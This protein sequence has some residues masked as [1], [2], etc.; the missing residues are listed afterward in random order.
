MVKLAGFAL[1]SL[2]LILAVAIWAQGAVVLVAMCVLLAWAAHSQAAL[3]RRGQAREARRQAL[4][5]RIEG[6]L[7]P[8]ALDYLATV[9][10][11]LEL[12]I[13]TRR[14]VRAELA[15]HL[16]D[17][18]A[19]I[20][21]EGQDAGFATRESMA[22]L[23]PADDLARDLSK[24]HQSTQQLLAGA[25]GG[26]WSAGIGAVQ[27]YIFAV[28]VF[29][30]AAI[31]FTIGLRPAV[32]FV[33][34]H[35]VRPNVDPNE[36]GFGTALGGMLAWPAAFVAGRRGVR[37]SAEISGRPAAR[38]GRWW[39]LASLLG[40]GWLVMF[41]VTVQQSWLVVV[42]EIGI[43]IAFATG[44]LLRVDSHL[45]NVRG[46]WGVAVAVAVLVVGSIPGLM[47]ASF[48]GGSVD[49]GWDT[50]YTADSIGWNHVAPQWPDDNM[51]FVVSDGVT[52]PATIQAGNESALASFRDLRIE[53]WRAKPYPGAP[54]GVF[55]G[56]LDTG[57]NAPFAT[58]PAV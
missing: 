12:P 23:G 14:E 19:A 2:A 1:A 28:T 39:A 54:S 9:N 31:L 8:E 53:A 32:D 57:Y 22:R 47:A 37:S 55:L 10:A 46:R 42:V 36:L 3:S 52:A 17:S 4:E 6:P 48:A 56:L 13:E 44:A 51:Q 26:V 29:L 34:A 16:S 27:G 40:L 18:I 21:A 20:Q 41:V 33:I 15:D 25:A 38:L 24:T 5:S 58:V 50:G 7:P 45:P 35:V 11:K 30:L 49:G 43:P